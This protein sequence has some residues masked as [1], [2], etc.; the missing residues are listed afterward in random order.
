[1]RGWRAV[2]AL[3]RRAR[4]GATAGGCAAG[5][6]LPGGAPA[7]GGGGGRAPPPGAGERECWACLWRGVAPAAGPPGAGPPAAGAALLANLALFAVFER[8]TGAAPPGAWRDLVEVDLETLDVRRRPVETDP[9][10]AAC[11]V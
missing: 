3:T 1:L 2:R 6:G 9:A 4:R 8:S 5:A 7:A 10:C 11:G